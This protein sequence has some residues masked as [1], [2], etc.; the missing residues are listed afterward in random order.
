M[1]PSSTSPD[2]QLINAGGTAL[3][4]AATITV[5]GIS[6]KNNLMIV[7]QGVSG[8]NASP[9]ISFRFNSDDTSGNYQ[10]TYIGATATTTPFNGYTSTSEVFTCRVGNSASDT[11]NSYLQVLGANATGLKT[12]WGI[13]VGNGSSTPQTWTVNGV[14]KGTSAITSVSILSDVGNFDAGTIFVYGA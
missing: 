12:F 7:A 13:G 5:S 10:Y 6:G 2:Y 4:G 9:Y 3:T 14:Y 11:A 8:V 1:A